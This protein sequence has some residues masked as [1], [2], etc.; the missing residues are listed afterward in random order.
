MEIPGNGH[1]VVVA[2]ARGVELRDHVVK[3][4]F[5]HDIA[6]RIDQEE[7]RDRMTSTAGHGPAPAGV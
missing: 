3:L 6:G 2:R 5:G 7:Q 1:R 4:R